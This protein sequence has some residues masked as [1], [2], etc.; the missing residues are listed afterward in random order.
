[1]TAI[2]TFLARSGMSPTVTA[3]GQLHF[4]ERG[5]DIYAHI[6]RR[7]FLNWDWEVTAGRTGEPLA[8][9]TTRTRG[10]AEVGAIA[11]AHRPGIAKAVTR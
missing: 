6:R 1:M 9:G 7:G 5:P 4:G 10:G 11:A 3:D 8:F 2:S